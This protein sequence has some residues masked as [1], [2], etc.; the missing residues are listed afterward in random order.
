MESFWLIYSR[1]VELISFMTGKVKNFFHSQ[2]SCKVNDPI[3]DDHCMVT[4]MYH[5]YKLWLFT[6]PE[7]PVKNN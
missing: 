4:V 3:R 7:W 2:M 6:F 5:I 1:A